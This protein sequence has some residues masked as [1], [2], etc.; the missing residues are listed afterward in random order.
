[1][2]DSNDE[3]CY[4]VRCGDGAPLAIPAWMTHPEAAYAKIVPAARLPV[5]VLLELHRV[6]V[7]SLAASEHNVLQEDRDAKTPS[8]PPTTTLR[9]NAGP[10][11]HTTSA[12][13]TTAT[14][15]GT[16]AVDAGVGQE[17]PEGGQR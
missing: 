6:I 16:G 10:T 9:R 8:K 12:G 15:P 7:T 14:P 13:R 3:S 2:Y 4:V 11:G 17:N 5:R 1:M